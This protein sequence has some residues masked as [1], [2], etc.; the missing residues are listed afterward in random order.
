[1]L[2][3]SARSETVDQRFSAIKDLHQKNY[4]AKIGDAYE[5]KVKVLEES[6]LNA[7][8]RAIARES[9]AGNLDGAVALRDEKNRVKSKEPLPETDEGVSPSIL[10]YRTTFRAETV[11]LRQQRNSA[12]L[13]LLE[14]FDA[15]LA[16]YQDELTKEGRLDDALKIKDYRDHGADL[17]LFGQAMEVAE[18]LPGEN[19]APPPAAALGNRASDEAA[20]TI[21]KW[22]LATP[23]HSCRIRYQGKLVEP[24]S[25]DDLP[26]R[27]IE[28][29][30]LRRR[31]TAPA[32]L[33]PFPWIFLPGVPHLET[34]NIRVVNP[35]S[36][37]DV[38][39]LG[40]L[41]NLKT[42]QLGGAEF[43][44]DAFEKAPPF[45]RL[46]K[47]EMGYSKGF[48][49]DSLKHLSR[50][51]PKLKDA[52]LGSPE[53]LWD[54]PHFGPLAQWKDLEALTLQGAG[55]ISSSFYDAVSQLPK[56]KMLGITFALECDPVAVPSFASLKNLK[57][58]RLNKSGAAHIGQ[59]LD[60][61]PNLTLL[62]LNG[63]FLS[64][65]GMQSLLQKA[66]PQL[67]GLKIPGNVNLTDASFEGIE[68]LNQLEE[69]DLSRIKIGDETLSRLSGMRKLRAL[70]LVDT[71]VTS[72][73][74]RHLDR[75]K[76][77]TALKLG[78]TGIS[79]AQIEDFQKRHPDCVISL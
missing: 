33:E 49:L 18:P 55:T 46:E 45:P 41:P 47:F 29:V 23:D 11:K 43:E 8:D 3:L 36:A 68:R 59:I 39:N 62:F 60:L 9:Q 48:N 50:Q 67:T 26:E 17:L 69:L 22:I 19:D 35:I 70:F 16:S 5:A 63:N 10:T 79:K 21:V 61:K 31:S 20:I 58:L 44:A 27:E 52:T 12:A 72:N 74:L 56:L 4:Q 40:R 13:P 78:G 14:Q 42:L 64:P 75:L 2:T 1:L 15:S 53:S 51:M 7:L 32:P 24:S 77:L 76:E 37:S 65:E 73:G 66:N 54:E 30:E 6:Y 38:A 25:L 28:I 71:K 34:F 57:E